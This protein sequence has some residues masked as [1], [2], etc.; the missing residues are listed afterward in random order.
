M[1]VIEL[2]DRTIFVDDI[3]QIYQEDN[4]NPI[5]YTVSTKNG[6]YR[7]NKEELKNKIINICIKLKEAEDE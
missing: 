3:K 6:D 7:I 1:K 2:S 4:Y 5:R